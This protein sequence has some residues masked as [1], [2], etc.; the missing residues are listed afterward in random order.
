[1]GKTFLRGVYEY[2]APQ[3]QGKGTLMMRDLKKKCLETGLWQPDQVYANFSVFIPGV[4]CMKN[5][6]LIETILEF[7]RDEVRDKIILFDEIGQELRARSYKE[8]EQTEVASFVWQMPK[9]NILLMFASNPGNS[10]DVILRDGAW[11]T[12]MPKYHYVN[13]GRDDYITAHVI[14]NYGC[15]I[16]GPYQI[17]DIREYQELFDSWE[18]VN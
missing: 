7:K 13:E 10:A 18:P 12:I 1:M 8:K 14:D 3:R 2:C 11:Y 9:M 16:L 15:R 6:T 5:K 4:H 17:P